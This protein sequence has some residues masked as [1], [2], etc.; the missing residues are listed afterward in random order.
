MRPVMTATAQSRLATLLRERREEIVQRFVERARSVGASEALPREDIIDSLREYLDELAAR[1]S[2]DSASGPPPP[3]SR[4]AVAASHG[5]QRFLSGYDIGAVVRE[6]SA[7]RELLCDVIEEDG[8][9]SFGEVRVLFKHL[10]SGIA[11]AAVEFGALRDTELRKR[12]SEHI[13]FL[14]HELR[15]PLSSARMAVTLI[16]QRGDVKPSRA[17]EALERGLTRAAELV[18]DALVTVRL[19]ELGALDCG[20]VDMGQLLRVVAHESEA[21][22]AAKELEVEVQGEGR[23]EADAKALRSAMSNLVRNAVKFSHPGG[24]VKIRGRS[25]ETRFVIEVEDSCGGLPEGTV[26]KLFDPFVQA[27]TDRSGFG[28]GL[29]IAKRV[30][31]AH[32]GELRVHDIPGKGCVFVLELPQNPPACAENA[33]RPPA[34]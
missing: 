3:V 2:R 5:E 7:L 12:T 34:P 19:R 18:D 24:I 32:G 21:D 30:T 23:I 29:A 20:P 27:G 22:A 15:N 25:A 26:K 17:F 13:G 9:L 8:R 10:V 4:S 33:G 16:S 6:Y 31:D 14:A 1:V 28:L 11:D